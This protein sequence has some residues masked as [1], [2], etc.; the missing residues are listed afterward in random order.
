MA[1]IGQDD[2]IFRRF[3]KELRSPQRRSPLDAFLPA[4][5]AIESAVAPPPA[6]PMPDLAAHDFGALADIDRD[7]EPS[8]PPRPKAK[9]K[10]A[11][12]ATPEKPKSL[13]D[14]IQEFMNR[15][16]PQAAAEDD[17]SAWTTGMDPNTDPDKDR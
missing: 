15:D 6:A 17:L 4:S 11:A 5:D 1:G 3:E 13:Q 2:D 12:P 16:R 10:R 7:P 9:R 8:P 14:E